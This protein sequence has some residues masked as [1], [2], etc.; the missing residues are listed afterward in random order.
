M[1]T[2]TS[3]T[4]LYA[5]VTEDTHRSTRGRRAA[6]GARLEIKWRITCPAPARLPV[7]P[8]AASMCFCFGRG[9]GERLQLFDLDDLSPSRG[10]RRAS[11]QGRARQS[12]MLCRCRQDRRRC[13]GCQ[14]RQ[15]AERERLV[16]FLKSYIV[17]NCDQID[18]LPKKFAAAPESP[19]SVWRTGS[20]RSSPTRSADCRRAAAALPS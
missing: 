5:K 17:F 11:S 7:S 8:I 4:D 1:S 10:A 9:D 15:G 14:G 20:P 12:R 18:G 13:A 3:R 16:R 19:P 6:L 2:D